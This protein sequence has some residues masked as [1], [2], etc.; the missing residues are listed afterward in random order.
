[1]QFGRRFFDE[2]RNADARF[3]IVDVCR[4]FGLRV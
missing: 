4:H 3:V 2:I 1:L